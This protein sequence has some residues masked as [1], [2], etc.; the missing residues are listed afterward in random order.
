MIKQ[1]ESEFANID[2][3]IEPNKGISAFVFYCVD[4][5]TG[6]NFGMV[7][8]TLM[9]FSVKCSTLSGG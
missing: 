7:C 6:H 5:S 3:Q 9:V 4:L 2:L 8:P 1:N